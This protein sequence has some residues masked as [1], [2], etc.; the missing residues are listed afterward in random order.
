MRDADSSQGNRMIRRMCNLASALSLLLCVATCVLWVRGLRHSDHFL[1]FQD[2]DMRFYIGSVGGDFALTRWFSTNGFGDARS[3]ERFSHG[4]YEPDASSGR[5]F[6]LP[7]V[8]RL[9][10]HQNKTAQCL[11]P[12]PI[13]VTME[14]VLP[15]AWLLA[16]RKRRRKPIQISR[17]FCPA[18]GYDLRASKERCPECGTK[19][20]SN[21]GAAA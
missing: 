11:I 18:C 8:V 2:E 12:Y 4:P 10:F 16:L 15:A 5:V 9:T 1:F 7:K 6:P 21:V 14:L 13:P 20:P 3:K 19:I 17:G